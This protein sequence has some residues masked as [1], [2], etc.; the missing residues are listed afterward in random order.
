MINLCSAPR[1]DV[2]IVVFRPY[3]KAEPAEAWVDLLRGGL[4][5]CCRRRRVLL[6]LPELPLEGASTQRDKCVSSAIIKCDVPC[7]VTA[8]RS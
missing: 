7:D 4:A 5:R 1:C 2:T 6:E 3:L 8:I